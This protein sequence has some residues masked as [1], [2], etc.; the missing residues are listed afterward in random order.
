MLKEWSSQG[1]TDRI[2]TVR[3]AFPSEY[4]SRKRG[5][6]H[7]REVGKQTITER[8]KE[9]KSKEIYFYNYAI[10]LGESLDVVLCHCFWLLCATFENSY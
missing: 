10:K 1:V 6:E 9:S 7:V 3:L 5:K 8:K 4:T 2:H